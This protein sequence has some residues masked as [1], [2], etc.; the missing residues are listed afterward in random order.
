M[1][2]KTLILSVYDSGYGA[3][4]IY[5][6]NEHIYLEEG[7]PYF[8]IWKIYNDVAL[9]KSF[10]YRVFEKYNFPLLTGKVLVK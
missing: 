10:A 7:K 9:P 4:S 1:D 3:K 8:D 2:N 6:N 5:V